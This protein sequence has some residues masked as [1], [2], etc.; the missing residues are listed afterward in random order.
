MFVSAEMIKLFQ[1]SWFQTNIFKIILF[2]EIFVMNMC[3]VS[4]YMADP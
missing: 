1:V 3:K 2:F 4:C